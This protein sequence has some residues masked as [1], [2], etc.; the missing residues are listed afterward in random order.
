[1]TMQP[2]KIVT[3]LAVLALSIACSADE[4]EAEGR[5]FAYRCE[6]GRYVVAHYRDASE[7]M[8][9][10]L[11]G[12]TVRLPRV[13]ATSGAKYSDGATMF[14]SQDREATL[15][16]GNGEPVGCL[17]D[18]RRSIIEDAK[19]RGM[20]F[21]AAGNEPG[22][23]LEIGRGKTVLV[24]N[25]GQDRYELETAEPTV[26][27]ENGRTTYTGRVGGREIAIQISPERCNDSMSG[28]SFG[29][30]VTVALDAQVLR[31]C[32]TALH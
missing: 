11:P 16:E 1:M 2:F 23:T 7:E 14:W 5:A 24:T 17:E 20:D 4:E 31:G 28:E 8:W 10:F 29:S 6:D 22:W 25:Y 18:R 30:T 27:E 21:W 12:E 32:G 9:L 19:L 15:Q 26:E 13:E 3:G